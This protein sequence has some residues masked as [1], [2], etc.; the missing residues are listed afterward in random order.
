MLI[1]IALVV[2][3]ASIIVFFSEELRKSVLRLV[4]SHRVQLIVPIF[5]CD[6]IFAF[7]ILK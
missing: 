2:F 6:G 1:T 7:N 3:A 5:F 4:K